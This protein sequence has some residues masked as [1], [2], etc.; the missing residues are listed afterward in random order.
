[1]QVYAIHSFLL[2]VKRFS[3][4]TASEPSYSKHECKTFP[5]VVHAKKIILWDA[6][7]RSSQQL[8]FFVCQNQPISHKI[9]RCESLTVTTA[10]SKHD[11]HRFVGFI[12]SKFVQPNLVTGII[13]SFGSNHACSDNIVHENFCFFLDIVA[14]E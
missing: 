3:H 5:A 12:L 8:M 10:L 7:K 4:I 13:W 1:M 11:V 14:C 6:D 2:Q 9:N